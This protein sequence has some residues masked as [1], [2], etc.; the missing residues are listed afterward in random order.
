LKDCIFVDFRLDMLEHAR[1]ND[2][3]RHLD[4]EDELEV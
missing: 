3:A 4:E 1:V 2:A